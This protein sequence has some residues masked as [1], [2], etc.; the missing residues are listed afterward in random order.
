MS[1]SFLYCF[2]KIIRNL[3][4]DFFRVYFV[5]KGHFRDVR[6][7]NKRIGHSLRERRSPANWEGAN[8]ELSDTVRFC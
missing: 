1:L 7:R 2:L 6:D 3:S 5:V 8:R 4:H